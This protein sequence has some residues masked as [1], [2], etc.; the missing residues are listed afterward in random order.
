M[1]PFET[2]KSITQ[3]KDNLYTNEEIFNKEYTPFMVNRIL[4]QSPSTALFANAMNQYGVLDKKL[5]Y[6]F[7]RVGIPKSKGYSKWIKKETTDLNQEHIDFIC[8]TMHL[9]LQRGIEVY[10]LIGSDAVQIQLDKR[11]GKCKKPNNK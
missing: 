2:T 5:Q 8:D 3:T 1:T 9:S 4:S 7:Y 11:G 6:D 10:S